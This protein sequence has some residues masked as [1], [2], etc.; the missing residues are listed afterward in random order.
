MLTGLDWLPIG[1]VVRLEGEDRFLVITGFMA[2][3]S[4]TPAYW[5]YVAV[6]YPLGCT[7]D[8]NGIYFDRS[9]IDTVYQMGYLNDEGLALMDE[10]A[11]TEDEFLEERLAA[12]LREGIIDENLNLI[13]KES[14]KASKTARDDE[15]HD[16][17]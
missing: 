11:S 8:P 12:L 1:S 14:R 7:E 9:M 15:S 16:N 17:V 6:P 5:E 10:L 13:P 3:D 2:W 4:K